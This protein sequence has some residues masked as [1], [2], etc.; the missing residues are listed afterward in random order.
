[1]VGVGPGA[2]EPQQRTL[3]LGPAAIAGKLVDDRAQSRVPHVAGDVPPLFSKCG[4]RLRRRLDEVA[5]VLGENV[6]LGPPGPCAPA[7]GSC[8]WWKS[9]R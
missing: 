1:M 8:R 3:R 2:K 5:I 7:P 9:L 4:P 6:L